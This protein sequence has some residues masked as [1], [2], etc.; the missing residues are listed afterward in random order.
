MEGIEVRWGLPEDE[1]RIAEL[2]EL[3]GMPRWVAYEER[4]I[5]AERGGAVLAGL[6]CRTEIE[7]LLLG[8][9]VV[10][11][12]AGEGPLARALYSS[13]WSLAREIGAREIIAVPLPY[14]DYPHDEV[15]Y[16]RR[17]RGWRLD[18]V[19]GRLEFRGELPASG[20]RRVVAL[21]GM[22]AVPF[23]RVARDW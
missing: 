15:G 6:R 13:A 1:P 20:W 12:W 22:C 10:A 17:G 3:N 16:R 5:V 7:R 14:T 8:L 19:T 2:L 23:F 9:L 11:P 21:L 18:V 4:F